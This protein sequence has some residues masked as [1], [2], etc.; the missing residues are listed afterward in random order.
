MGPAP[1]PRALSA[2][3]GAIRK[4]PTQWWKS[5]Y[6]LEGET[7]A[8][9]WGMW[10]ELSLEK[11]DLSSRRSVFVTYFLKLYTPVNAIVFKYR[12]ESITPM[13]LTAARGKAGTCKSAR[14]HTLPR[15]SHETNGFLQYIAQLLRIFVD[16]HVSQC[17]RWGH[18][19]V[20]DLPRL[21]VWPQWK[22]LRILRRGAATQ[23]EDQLRPTCCNY[24]KHSNVI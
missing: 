23:H 6:S 14:M 15:C 16:V 8:S 19:H 1:Q 22:H 18:H 9:R 2:S 13:A 10:T 21:R 20:P 5:D 11:L 17:E 12:L 24:W 7:P 4:M 3:I